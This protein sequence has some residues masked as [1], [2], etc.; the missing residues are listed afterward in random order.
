MT[1]T[2]AGSGAALPERV[3]T[4]ADFAHLDSSDE[5]IVKRTG[6]RER[7]WLDEHTPLADLAVAAC[8]RALADARLDAK[9]LQQVVVAT[10]T[11]DRVSP[12]LAVE[13]ATRLGADRPAAFDV[14]A[15][16]SGFLYALDHAIAVVES[17]RAE[18]VLVCGAEALSRITDKTDRSTAVL[19]GDG[20][21]A[22]VVRAATGALRPAFALGSDGER[23]DL[24]YVGKPDHLLRMRGRE[25]Y[26]HAVDAMV[27]STEQVLAARGLRTDDLDLLV[28]HQANARIVRAVARRLAVPDE[29]VFLNI[30]RVANTSA[31]SIPIALT[32]ARESGVLRPGALLGLATF[33]AGLT[34]GA[35]VISWKHP[36]VRTT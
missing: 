36:G 30:E 29:K 22:V 3:V 17:G 14:S 1:V 24:L 5:W 7:R 21:G 2:L 28:A 25:I 23:I 18:N 11:A 26:E 33:G 32:H 13:V 12:G 19:L 20:A 34:W 4:N 27:G 15:G 31:A 10:S 8:E 6:I 16:C 9:E 35:G